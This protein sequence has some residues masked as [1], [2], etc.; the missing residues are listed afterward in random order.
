[1]SR[2]CWCSQR[3]TSPSCPTWSSQVEVIMVSSLKVGVMAGFFAIG[4]LGCGAA[5]DDESSGDTSVG[6]DEVTKGGGGGSGS[7]GGTTAPKKTFLALG[8]SI[9]FGMN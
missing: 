1:M 8:D 2:T 3:A 9:A 4:L 7:G 6:T 5:P